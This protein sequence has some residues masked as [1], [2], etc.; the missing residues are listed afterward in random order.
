V[1][2][3]WCLFRSCAFLALMSLGIPR[4]IG[5]IGRLKPC[6]RRGALGRR[7]STVSSILPDDIYDVVIVGG[8]IAGLALATRLRI[9]I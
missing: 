8:G 2:I 4:S 6:L 5:R 9:G 7:L 1:E 3:D